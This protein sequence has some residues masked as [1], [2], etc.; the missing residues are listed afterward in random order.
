MFEFFY[1]I[2]CFILAFIGSDISGMSHKQSVFT[3]FCI[4]VLLSPIFGWI[5]L[6][7]FNDDEAESDDVKSDDSVLPTGETNLK[8]FFAHEHLYYDKN[9]EFRR[10]TEFYDE[11]GYFKYNEFHEDGTP[12]TEKEK[13][14]E[15]IIYNLDY[16]KL[17]KLETEHLEHKNNYLL[18]YD[19]KGNFQIPKKYYNEKGYYRYDEFHKNGTPLNENEKRI[20]KIKLSTE[21]KI[22][23][24]IEYKHLEFE[25]N[26][27]LYYDENGNFQ[28]PKEYYDENGRYKYDKFYLNGISRNE[29]PTE[30]TLRY[31]MNYEHFTRHI[32]Y[33]Y[34]NED[35]FKFPYFCYD[36]D[37]LLEDPLGRYK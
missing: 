22:K 24:N 33:Y 25:K 12:K 16:K 31:Q 15:H 32:D 4:Y 13:K 28:I 8:H 29:E 30:E 14:T 11:K 6:W 35:N 19:D 21:Y 1:T 10:P 3:K 26:S 23:F 9:G 20:Q 37:L 7:V 17:F 2:I 18:Y 5:L 27:I 34:D 36:D